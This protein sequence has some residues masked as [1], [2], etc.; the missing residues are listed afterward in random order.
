MVQFGGRAGPVLQDIAHSGGTTV[1]TV[2]D[3]SGLKAQFEE[4]PIT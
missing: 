2:V 4:F 1:K 3:T